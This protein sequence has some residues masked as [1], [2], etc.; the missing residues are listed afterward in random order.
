[1]SI[2]GR[3]VPVPAL[4]ALV[5]LLVVG[6]LLPVL[7][8]TPA[9]EIVL[10]ADGM[11][12]RVEGGPASANPVIEVRAGEIVRIVL[13]NEERGMQH[14]FA[15]PALGVAL[16]LVAWTDQRTLTFVAPSE[17]GD[18]E[19]ICRPHQL[20]MRGVLRVLPAGR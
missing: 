11:A 13:R 18:Y 17:P 14:D 3:Q 20:M 9:Q 15:V 16:D 19:Y 5:V 12:F 4:A 10:V 2:Y 7:S 6:G 1:M 8:S